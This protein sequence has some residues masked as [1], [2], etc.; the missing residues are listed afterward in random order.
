MKR[1]NIVFHRKEK[2]RGTEN[3]VF[4]R[5]MQPYDLYRCAAYLHKYRGGLSGGFPLEKWGDV[6]ISGKKEAQE[7]RVGAASSPFI[8]ILYKE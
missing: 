6:P 2:I 4:T 8:L 5:S 7:E 3:V 1:Q